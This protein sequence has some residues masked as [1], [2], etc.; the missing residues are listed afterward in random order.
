MHSFIESFNLYLVNK[1][2]KRKSSGLGKVLK[3][4]NLCLVNKE[5]GFGCQYY[6]YLNKFQ[7]MSS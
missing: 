7:S 2:L 5:R 1:E 3:S 6:K 4:F